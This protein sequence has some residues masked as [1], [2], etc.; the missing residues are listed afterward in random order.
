MV[1]RAGRN[2]AV[3]KEDCPFCLI[4]RGQDTDAVV[5]YED[6]LT[7]AFTPLAPATRGHTL[8]VPRMHVSS[9]WEMSPDD[10]AGVARATVAV[11]LAIRTALRPPAMNVIQ[12]NGDLATQ[13]VDHVH[14]HIVPRWAGDRIKLRWPRG[15]AETSAKQ[16]LTADQIRLAVRLPEN[17]HVP[18]SPEDRRQHLAFIQSVISRMA[19]ASASAKTWLLPIV[20]ATY[21]YAM[22]ERL[23][24]VAVLGMFAV[25][26]FGLLDAN[27][28]KQERAFRSLYDKVSAGAPIPAFAMNPTVAGP[29]SPA[30]SNYWPDRADWLSW[31]IAA[32]YPPILL[33]GAV[34]ITVLTMGCGSA[35]A[36]L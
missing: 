10:A 26:V 15:A 20:T 32:V 17:G 6:A 16:R 3:T 8:V 9:I 24:H 19:S 27:Y 18:V 13:T 30:R 21:G 22:V 2:S 31:S 5:V 36:R 4:I 14:V 11:S 33:V 23:W 7:V 12:S 28:L 25:L 1:V 29:K 34:I 35:A